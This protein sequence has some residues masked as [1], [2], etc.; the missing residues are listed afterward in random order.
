VKIAH[1]ASERNV[2]RELVELLDCPR[3]LISTNGSY[4]K[5]PIPA[6]VS[7]VIK[8]GGKR[9]TLFFNYRTQYTDVWDNPRWQTTY[10]YRVVYPDQKQNGTLTVAL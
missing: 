4:F 3:Y 10:D 1:H 9:P 2:S 7:R 5:H 6:A 8:F